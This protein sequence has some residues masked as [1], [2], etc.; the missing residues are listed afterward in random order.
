MPLCVCVYVYVCVCVCMCVCVCVCV[1]ACVCVCV[2]VCVY[3][4]A[5]VCVR[6]CACVRAVRACVRVRARCRC[7]CVCAMCL[8]VCVCVTQRPW[9]CGPCCCCSVFGYWRSAMRTVQGA[10]GW[11][12]HAA[13]STRQTAPPPRLY[14][15]VGSGCSCSHCC[16]YYAVVL[17]RGVPAFP[18]NRRNRHATLIYQCAAN[19]RPLLW[20]CFAGTLPLPCR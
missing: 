4:C 9:H 2:C 20:S 16:C 17:F 12:F 1:R 3:V 8:C 6:V 10:V 7:V 14:A 19:A 18:I 11:Y 5:Y 15:G 13:Y